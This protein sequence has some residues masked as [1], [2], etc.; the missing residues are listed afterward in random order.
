MA[1]ENNLNLFVIDDLWKGWSP[2]KRVDVDEPM[3]GEKKQM[4]FGSEKSAGAKKWK[5]KRNKERKKYG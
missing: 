5:R 3:I 1:Q 4:I 2:L